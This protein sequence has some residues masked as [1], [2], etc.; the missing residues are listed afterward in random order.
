MLLCFSFTKPVTVIHEILFTYTCR[1]VE[2]KEDN[3]RYSEHYSEHGKLGESSGNSVQHWVD[4]V[5]NKFFICHSD[6]CA[7]QLLTG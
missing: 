2:E 7:K 5:A 4:I 3:L 1:I 6:L